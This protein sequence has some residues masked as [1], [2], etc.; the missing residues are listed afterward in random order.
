V[1]TARDLTALSEPGEHCVVNSGAH[2]PDREPKAQLSARPR[3]AR[4]SI[5]ANDILAGAF[6]FCRTTPIDD[7][8]MPRLASALGVGVTSI[9]WYFKSKTELID[10][11]TEQAML[12]FYELMPPLTSTGWE[13]ILEEFFTDY[14]AVLRSDELLCDL[15]VRRFGNYTEKGALNSWRR[16]EELLQ[17]L[18]EAGF[19]LP[20]ATHAYYTLLTYTQGFLFIERSQRGTRSCDR[21]GPGETANP[22]VR[23]ELPLVTEMGNTQLSRD[24]EFGIQNIIRGLRPLLTEPAMIQPALTRASAT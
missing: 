15:I 23:A 5:N 3:R 7:L 6:D 1:F 4:G 9:Y 13:N 21:P 8:S 2:V 16:T 11:M 14:Y 12:D 17:A 19:A 22:D 10:A 24:F 20:V 18:V